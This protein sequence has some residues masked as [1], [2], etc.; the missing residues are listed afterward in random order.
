MFFIRIPA[1]ALES[2]QQAMESFP[3]ALAVS[4]LQYELKRMIIGKDDWELTV[5][6]SAVTCTWQYFPS[7]CRASRTIF[8]VEELSADRKRS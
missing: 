3:R 1:L 5:A 7:A 8:A 6:R 2:E 4:V